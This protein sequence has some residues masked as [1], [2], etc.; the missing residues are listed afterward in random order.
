MYAGA[1]EKPPGLGGQNFCL[2]I[3][4]FLQSISSWLSNFSLRM[5][6]ITSRAPGISGAE[7]RFLPVAW[8]ASVHPITISM[9]NFPLNSTLKSAGVGMIQARNHSKKNR[10]ILPG[11]EARHL[12]RNT[13]QFSTGVSSPIRAALGVDHR[14]ISRPEPPI[15]SLPPP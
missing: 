14:G 1:P 3:H 6:L 7:R 4:D 15:H 12:Q 13:F 2:A 5:G 11:V 9:F 8:R 10:L